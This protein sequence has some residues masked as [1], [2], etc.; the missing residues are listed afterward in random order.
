VLSRGLGP[1]LGFVLSLVEVAVLL[2][3][4]ALAASLVVSIGVASLLGV[5]GLLGGW[6]APIAWARLLA[7]D[8]ATFWGG[9]LVLV[10]AAAIVGGGARRFQVAQRWA[11]LLAAIGTLVMAGAMWWG[12]SASFAETLLARTGI[13]YDGLIETARAGGWRADSG[14]SR[15]T[16]AFVLWPLLALLGAVQSLAL[17][18]ETERPRRAQG[19]AMFGAL[20][21]SALTLAAFSWLAERALGGAFQGAVAWHSLHLIGGGEIETAL[22]AMPWLPVLVA[23]KA[24]SV[25]LGAAMLIGFGAWIWLWVPGQ[26]AYV[27]RVITAWSR[28]GLV[29]AVLAR[30]GMGGAG[31]GAAL[32]AAPGAVWLGTAIAIGFLALIVHGQA[33]FLTSAEML[34]AVWGVGLLATAM[35]PWRRPDLLRRLRAAGVPAAGTLSVLCG[36]GGAAF[37]MVG[38]V[39][40]WLDPAVGGPLVSVAGLLDEAWA[41]LGLLVLGQFWYVGARILMRRRGVDVDRLLH[42]PPLE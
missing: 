30:G 23:I 17:A 27:A 29:P 37:L 9:A 13:S 40:L 3:Y 25:A 5:V 18:G 14:V 28:D 15:Q 20:F 33:L 38:V 6:P 11:F 42:E 22:G 19:I 24:D 36:A 1:G 26:V 41:L 8:D 35:L 16:L 39:A 21:L 4:A 31:R 12:D 10:A 32:G 7:G 34:L 2:Y